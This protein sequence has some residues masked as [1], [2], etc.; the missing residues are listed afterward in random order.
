[1]KS[2]NKISA[3]ILTYNEEKHLQR[4]IDSIKN[5]ATDIYVIDS[6]SNDKTR[7]IA[8]SNKTHYCQKEFITYADKFN[9]ALENCGI[10]DGWIWRIDA[11]EYITNELALNINSIM[12]NI[13]D[14]IS[15][16]LVK[17]KIVFL[18]KPIMHGGWYPNWY[19]K[20]FR[21]GHAYCENRLLDEHI[22]LK[23]G[24]LTKVQGDQVDENLN[25]LSSWVQKHNQYSTREMVEHFKVSFN[26]NY[27]HD[28]IIPRLFGNAIEKKRWLKKRY[29]ELPLF[30]RPFLFF[31]YK[32][33]LQFG[34]LD[35]KSGLIWHV[36]QGFW[37]RFLVDAK[38]YETRKACGNNKETVKNYLRG[39]YNIEL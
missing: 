19:L 3:I 12:K 39:K 32:Y 2:V 22:V 16:I 35:G 36:L 27:Y 10:R 23:V 29:T 34:F 7:E 31:L 14:D 15:G 9:W 26:K 38:I 33:L 4:C 6:F 24:N 8:L 20:L 25:N 28:E 11:D 5:I 18:G 30:I 13:T 1:M 21:F 37:Y 17:R